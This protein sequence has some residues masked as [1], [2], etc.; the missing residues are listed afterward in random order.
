MGAKKG[1]RYVRPRRNKRKGKKPS[2]RPEPKQPDM[3]Y[4][5][6]AMLAF[7]GG[8]RP[9]HRCPHCGEWHHSRNRV[10]I[11]TDAGRRSVLYCTNRNRMYR[12]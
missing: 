7:T 6:W 8:G 2:E 9:Y 1:G 5:E 11:L 3:S 12:P 4:Q 10:R